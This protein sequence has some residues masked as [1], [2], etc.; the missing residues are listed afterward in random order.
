MKL[1]QTAYGI[2]G[3]AALTILAI[4]LIAIFQRSLLYFPDNTWYLPADVG[5]SGV[6][7]L[8]LD[9]A[10]GHKIVAWHLPAA[11]GKLTFLY[12]HGNGG[13]LR[14]RVERFKQFQQAGF[15]LFMVSYR[16][17]SGGTGSPSERALFADARLAYD[18]LRG[19]GRSPRDIALYGESLGTGVAV[20]LATER[21]IAAVVLDAPYT[22][23]VDMGR[24][25]YPYLPVEALLIDRFETVTFISKVR[26]PI[27]IMHGANDTS[28]PV[29]MG[30]A[31]FEM[32]PEPNVFEVIPGA[33]HSNIFSFDALPRLQ[34]FVNS[35]V[36]LTTATGIK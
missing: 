30:K 10:D 17:F 6:Q 35:H 16:G 18:Y 15:G 3:I 24:R 32:A 36:P 13:G 20:H 25:R 1:M 22:S 11:N 5:L 2:A 26:A 33:G 31:L 34:R 9:T 27:L 7:E 4:A 14:S 29:K 8:M 28:I 21:E 19:L 23:M 12:F